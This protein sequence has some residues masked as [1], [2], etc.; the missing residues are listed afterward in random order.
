VLPPQRINEEKAEKN[1][2]ARIVP[3][4]VNRLWCTDAMMF[5]TAHWILYWLFAVLD[6]HFDEVRG[7]HVVEQGGGDGW[8][9]LRPVKQAQQKV[10]ATMGRNVG[11]AIAL[12]H[13]WERQDIAWQGHGTPC[14]PFPAADSF[15]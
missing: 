15:R 11:E 12:R 1:H 7:V 3:D 8:A 14:A 6:H 9:T 10:R 5:G 4:T 13:D 2:G